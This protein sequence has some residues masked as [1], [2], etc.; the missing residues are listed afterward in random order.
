MNAYKEL[1]NDKHFYNLILFFHT[2]LHSNIINGIQTA[3]VAA[4]N[5]K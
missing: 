5:G 4:E 2:N 3:A 1:L